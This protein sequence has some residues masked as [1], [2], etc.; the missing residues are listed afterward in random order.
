MPSGSHTTDA[1]SRSHHRGLQSDTAVISD[2][3]EDE[4]KAIVEMALEEAG[5]DPSGGLDFAAFEA[6]LGSADLLNMQVELA[7][8]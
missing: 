3:S 1:G 2:C 7:L 5:V 6:A 4:M 8:S